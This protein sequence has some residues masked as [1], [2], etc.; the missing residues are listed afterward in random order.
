M[1]SQDFLPNINAYDLKEMG[2]VSQKASSNIALIKYWGK[3][4]VQIPVN[5][6]LSYTLSNCYTKTSIQ[7]KRKTSQGF[8]VNVFLN[9][10][11]APQFKEKILNFFEIAQP[12][13][14]FIQSYTFEIKTENT[15]PHSSGIASSASGFGALALC[16]IEIEKQLGQNYNDQFAKTKASFIA[17]LG[18]GSACRSI[19]NGLVLWGDHQAIKDSNKRY[20]IPYPYEIHPVF[21]TF[22]DT[23]LVVEKDKKKISST[24]GH[25]LMNTNPYK[26][27]RINSAQENTKELISI[28]KEGDLKGFGK[29]VE[30]E[31][32]S[33]H[34]MMMTSLPPFILMHENTLKVINKVWAFREDSGLPLFFTLDAGS[35]IHLLY[36]EENKTKIIEFINQELKPL[37]VE[38]QCIYDKVFF[39]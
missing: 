38:N 39:D 2:E 17:R 12:F 1:R 32:L 35:S 23:I 36:P 30:H 9:G 14:P 29:I 16:L 11:E 28:L 4:E 24:K 8:D 25:D 10:E 6:S 27:A 34:G 5:T 13:I 22:H 37:C 31:A 26:E 3:I 7:F 21:K 20:A 33:L 15:F 19:Y 18:S